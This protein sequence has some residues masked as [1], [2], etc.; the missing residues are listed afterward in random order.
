MG[1]MRIRIVLNEDVTDLSLWKV[2]RMTWRIL[3]RSNDLKMSTISPKE[4]HESGTREEK[5]VSAPPRGQE[6]REDMRRAIK[7]GESTAGGLV[8][9]VDEGEAAEDGTMLRVGDPVS[10]G[11]MEEILA[12]YT[13]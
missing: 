3:E 9:G 13:K 7:R 2:S 5:A 11:L 1:S 4:L 6:E 12:L 8:E 10:L